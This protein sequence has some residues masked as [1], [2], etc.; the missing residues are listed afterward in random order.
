MGLLVCL[1]LPYRPISGLDPGDT[2]FGYDKRGGFPI[3]DFDLQ[4]GEF[5]NDKYSQQLNMF[6]DDT[7]FPPHL[8]QDSNTEHPDEPPPLP[9]T[10]T[11]DTFDDIFGS[12][13]PS[14]TLQPNAFAPEGIWHTTGGN[15]EPSDIPRLREKHET[16]GYRDGV[17]KGKGETVQTGF[18][19][20]YGL[21]AVLGLRIGK[22]L[23]IL[24]GLCGAV[25]AGSKGD[26]GGE[27]E[28]E[29]VKVLGLL[30][31]GKRELKTESLF[32][33]EWWGEDG[34][35]KFEVPGEMKER[36]EVVFDDVA[37]AHPLVKKWEATVEA[38]VRKWGV[39]LS[40]LENEHH[41][42]QHTAGSIVNNAESGS[43][44][45][46]GGQMQELSW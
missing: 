5:H 2:K 39:D 46:L 30:E 11:N 42:D 23:G 14:P 28:G 6:R 17:T 7:M 45:K 24:E 26:N 38:E 15:S 44:P 10:H 21:G 43:P 31:E 12:E 20:G 33:V 19:E 25:T 41:T 35:W 40:L 36:C 3:R 18:D 29:R 1:L 37:G 13:P 22:V 9:H 32:A 8:P 34:I 4:E 27:W 16:E